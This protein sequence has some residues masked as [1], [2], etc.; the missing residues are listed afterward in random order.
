M[1][2]TKDDLKLR[3]DEDNRLYFNSVLP[4]CEFAVC[5]LNFLGQYTHPKARNGKR[6][7]RIWLTST[8][9]W[10]EE[11][12]KDVLIHEM[13]HH[14]VSEVDHRPNM[15]SFSWYGLF[16]HGKR[17]SRQ[18][19]RL[20]RDYGLKIYIHPHHIYHKHEKIPTTRW[21]KFVRFIG[22]NLN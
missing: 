13:I 18:V 3:F 20:K 8:V 9:E 11:S 16:G 21:G 15:D 7:C 14:Y 19:K 5:P 22:H 17:F 12:L 1:K 2:I 4:K 10:H 6:R